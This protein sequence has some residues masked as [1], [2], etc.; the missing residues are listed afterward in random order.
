MGNNVQL[1]WTPSPSPEV[2]AYMIY[3][4]IG[5][6][7]DIIDTVFT[8][9]TYLDTGAAPT[10]RSEEYYVLALDQ[11]GNTSQFLDPTRRSSFRPRRIPCRQ[12]VALE[13]NPYEIGPAASKA[14]SYGWS[15]DGGRFRPSTPWEERPPFMSTW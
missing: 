7:V 3:R 15:I 14:G 8:G 10:L 9:N 4:L 5:T 11:C 13:W 6:N 12:L 2:Y 1:T